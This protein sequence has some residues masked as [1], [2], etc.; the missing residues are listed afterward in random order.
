MWANW[1]LPVEDSWLKSL[2]PIRI[3]PHD[4]DESE[5]DN[6]DA[7]DD[8]AEVTPEAL[9]QSKAVEANDDNGDS[10]NEDDKLAA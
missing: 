6:D 9:E 3:S 10:V 8:E 7:A 4:D 2:S 5:D 1:L